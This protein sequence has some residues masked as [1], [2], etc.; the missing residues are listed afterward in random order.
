MVA[1]IDVEAALTLFTDALF[2]GNVQH[3]IGGAPHDA[4]GLQSVALLK[5][6][7][8]AER[9]SGGQILIDGMNLSRISS[10][11]GSLDFL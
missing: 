3:A 8:L 5:V 4:I 6:L 9:A 10:G 7:Y 2:G 11:K 1:L